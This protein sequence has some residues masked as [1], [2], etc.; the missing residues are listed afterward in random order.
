[1][2]RI[3]KWLFGIVALLL[4]SGLAIG[5]TADTDAA[6]MKAKYGGPASQFITLQPGLTVHVRDEGRRGAPVIVLIHGS[7]SSLHTWEPWIAQL[8]GEYRVISLDLPGHGLTGADPRGVYDGPAYVDVVER[9]MVKLGVAKAVIGG[10]SMGG[11]VSW[12]FPSI[13][14]CVV[15]RKNAAIW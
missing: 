5:Y 1:M 14:F 4:I 10:N 9:V 13:G 12:M 7:N 2:K 6:A 3:F 11:G 15:F 8:K